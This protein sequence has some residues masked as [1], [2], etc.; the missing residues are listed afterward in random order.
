MPSLRYG[1]RSTSRVP[2]YD[3]NKHATAHLVEL[4]ERLHEDGELL[5][6]VKRVHRPL[7]KGAAAEPHVRPQR[8]HL[9]SL[10]TGGTVARPAQPQEK[11]KV[12]PERQARGEQPGVHDLRS[13]GVRLVGDVLREEDVFLGV[14]ASAAP[15]APLP[16]PRRAREKAATVRG[17]DAGDFDVAA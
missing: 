5:V 16:P 17:E 9:H 1:V 8:E 4:H 3:G 10:P 13:V 12:L 15:E 11:S 6:A 14:D 2:A 7:L